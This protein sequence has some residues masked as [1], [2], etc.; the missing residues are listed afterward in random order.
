M[1]TFKENISSKQTP[2]KRPTLEEQLAKFQD[3]L[4][5]RQC[6][7]GH[8]NKLTNTFSEWQSQIGTD[9]ELTPVEITDI[10]TAW[11]R[12]PQRQRVEMFKKWKVKLDEQA[13]YKYEIKG[14]MHA[15]YTP[16]RSCILFFV[17]GNLSKSSM[18]LIGLM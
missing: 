12:D 11:P 7:N 1:A 3:D 10:E 8:L 14:M 5:N 13:T 16:I 2:G 9:L 4:L 6:A 15:L 18:K 17:L